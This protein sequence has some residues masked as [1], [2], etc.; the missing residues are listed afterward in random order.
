M[1]VAIAGGHGKIAMR[2]TGRLVARGVAVTSLIRDPEQAEDIRAIGAEP[3]VCDL[4]RA[5][6]EDLAE[7]ISSASAVVFAA[8]A[9]PGS[10]P[11]RKLTM[12]R[13]GAIKL[14]QA[15]SSLDVSRYLIVSSIGAEDPPAGDDAFSVYLRAKAEAD[16]AVQASDR[17][18]TIVRPGPLTDG[19]GRGRVRIEQRPFRGQV[20]RDDVAAVLDALLETAGAPRLILYVSEGEQTIEEAL[21]SCVGQTDAGTSEAR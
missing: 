5:S 10:G 4:E 20:P 6:L 2:L 19:P 1:V 3:V 8:G 15:A 11:E 13:D 9:G 16:A 21:A 18:W 17:E 12:D 7:A 14:L